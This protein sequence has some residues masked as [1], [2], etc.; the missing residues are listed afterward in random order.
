MLQNF[1]GKE[2]DT[3]TIPWYIDNKRVDVIFRRR[4]NTS[5]SQWQVL[6]HATDKTP[7]T[8]HDVTDPQIIHHLERNYQE[9]AQRLA[10]QARAYMLK[11]KNIN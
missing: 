11:N 2:W 6:E 5:L 7:D 3:V 1:G 10:K 9:M 8:W 4:L